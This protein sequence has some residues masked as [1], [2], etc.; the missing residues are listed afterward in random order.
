MATS[1]RR[2]S[3]PSAVPR[4]SLSSAVSMAM[5]RRGALSRCAAPAAL[6]AQA[7]RDRRTSLTKAQQRDHARRQRHANA[8]DEM[9]RSGRGCFAVLVAGPRCLRV[10]R[11]GDAQLGPHDGELGRGMALGDAGI[12][13]LA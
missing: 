7:A 13:L 11:A 1:S 5:T 10:A 2:A 4:A 9:L 3:L 8:L 6:G 12:E